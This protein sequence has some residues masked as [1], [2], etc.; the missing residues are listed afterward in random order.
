MYSPGVRVRVMSVVS[1]GC[2]LLDS[3][4]LQRLQLV[5]SFAN[6]V[7]VDLQH[8]VKRRPKLPSQLALDAHSLT[9]LSSSSICCAACLNPLHKCPQPFHSI[10]VHSCQDPLDL[11]KSTLMALIAEADE[12]HAREDGRMK[13][14]PNPKLGAACGC[15]RCSPDSSA[16]FSILPLPR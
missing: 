10:E 16:S 6:P 5:V 8:E 14:A 4:C 13:G 3:L 7:F 11:S 2:L 12:V 15:L 9:C 1:R